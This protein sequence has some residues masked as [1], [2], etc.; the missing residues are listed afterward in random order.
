MKEGDYAPLSLRLDKLPCPEQI[1]HM[2]ILYR[3]PGIPCN[4]I[5]RCYLCPVLIGDIS[6][7]LQTTSVSLNP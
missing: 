1:K 6:F 7:F 5:G 4:T 2:R 3:G